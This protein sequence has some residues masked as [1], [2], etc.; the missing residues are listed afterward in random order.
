MIYI[1][2]LLAILFSV[3]FGLSSYKR[4]KVPFITLGC[5]IL[6]VLIMTIL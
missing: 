6:L 2:I 4:I 5:S 1:L 3:I